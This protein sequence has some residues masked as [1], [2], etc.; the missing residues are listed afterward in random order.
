MTLSPDRVE[1]A[2]NAPSPLVGEPAR[3]T[4]QRFGAALQ[5]AIIGL[6]AAFSFLQFRLDASTAAL[7]MAIALVGGAALG[8]SPARR[9]LW[10]IAGL[11]A[12]WIAL[13]AFTPLAHYAVKNSIAIDQGGNADAVVVLGCGVMKDGTP[14]SSAED[15]I[16]H[17]SS[18]VRQGRAHC[19]VLCG[20]LWTPGIR[21]QLED[22]S[23]AIT[24]SW[25]G[26]VVNTH[27]EALATERL[28]RARGWK[29]VIVVTQAWH[30]RRAAAVF[31]TTGLDVLQSS[32]L[33]TRYD[34]TDPEQL[35]DRFQA[36][37]D[38]L[39]EAIG[40]RVYQMRGW[41]RKQVRA[42]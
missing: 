17:A 22:P 40:F 37:R 3:C 16:S 7:S 33:E 25:S 23:P 11:A 18:I 5:G 26:P 2:G 21:R 12:A 14:S 9:L 41:I 29:R 35:S 4:N 27:D 28:A 30:M 19:V 6:L 38:W 15:R 39:H 42:T 13:I 32:A 36:V 31:R 20:V 8:V 10:W 34:L 24:V 1:S